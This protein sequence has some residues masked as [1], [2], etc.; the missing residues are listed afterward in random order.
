MKSILACVVV[1]MA[2]FASAQTFTRFNPPP[3]DFSDTFYGDNGVDASKTGELNS[4]PDGR[5]RFNPGFRQFGPP[6]T[7]PNQANFVAPPH[8]PT[9]DPTPRNFPILPTT[10]P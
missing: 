3:C 10:D 4:E 1:T 9:T 6:A 8:C 5:F 7:Q 2:G